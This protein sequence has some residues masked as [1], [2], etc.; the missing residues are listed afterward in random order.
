MCKNVFFHLRGIVSILI[1]FINTVFWVIPIYIAAIAKLLIPQKTFRKYCDIVLNTSA[2][3]WVWVNNMTQRIFCNIRLHVSGTESLRPEGWYLV[4]SN[5]QSWTDILVLQ[6]IFHG[7]IPFLKFFLKQQLFWFPI[8]GQAWWALDF[9]FMKRYSS[10][11]IKKNPHLKGRDLET[12][13]KAC[14]KFKSIPVS[15]MNFAEG[16]R[17]TRQKHE[18]QKS[19]FTHLLKP[20]AG[21]MAFTLAAMGEHLHS[22]IDVT[23]AY[24]GEKSFWDF[25]CGRVRDIRVQVRTLPIT[26]EMLGDYFNDSDF[27]LAFQNWVNALW[28]QKDAC[29]QEMISAPEPLIP[30]SVP[31]F[32]PFRIPFPVTEK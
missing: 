12:T 14:E 4:V 29:I 9:P 15:V 19:P 24:P 10:A 2:G 30:V 26:R 17:F 21:G 18:R 25:L 13:R 31:S 3:N 5:H 23:I 22:F 28:Q 8:I 16:T 27:R 11:F 7:K 32:P 1:Y 6:R 20:K